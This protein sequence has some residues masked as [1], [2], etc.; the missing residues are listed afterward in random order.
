MKY[1]IIILISLFTQNLLLAQTLPPLPVNSGSS[2][3]GNGDAF[4][5]DYPPILD[6]KNISLSI[7]NNHP[8]GIIGIIDVDVS[9]D[10]LISNPITS[11]QIDNNGTMSGYPSWALGNHEISIDF[12]NKVRSSKSDGTF[13][14][15][16]KITYMTDRGPHSVPY[17]RSICIKDPTITLQG[18]GKKY[19]S[20]SNSLE[21]DFPKN[22]EGLDAHILDSFNPALV[23]N[24]KDADKPVSIFVTGLSNPNYFKA[25]QSKQILPDGK[26][27]IG[28]EELPNGIYQLVIQQ[29]LEVKR[30]KFVS[31]N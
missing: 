20:Q 30:L 16:V 21:I 31:I 5:S 13:Y 15:T 8:S 18:G 28:L 4:C 17:E 11:I 12:Q 2:S 23:I 10:Y 14:V 6:N 26:N 24:N 29:G 27:S 1:L 25:V 9:F 22:K 7:V 3:A 19:G